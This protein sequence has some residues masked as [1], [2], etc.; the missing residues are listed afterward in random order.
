[1][2][3]VRLL[4]ERDEVSSELFEAAE[5]SAVALGDFVWTPLVPAPDEYGLTNPVLLLLTLD[6]AAP[7]STRL[8]PVFDVL[9]M[10]DLAVLAALAETSQVVLRTVDADGPDVMAHVPW[11]EM[12][13]WINALLRGGYLKLT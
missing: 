6:F 13:A 2:A 10:Q 9:G 4:L 1:M 5:G 8:R 7:L 11:P 12:S 3:A